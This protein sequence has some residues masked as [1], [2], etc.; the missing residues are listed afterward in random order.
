VAVNIDYH[1]DYDDHYYSVHYGHYMDGHREMEVRATD[2]TV[3]IL[4]AG[5][6]VASHVRSFEKYRHSTKPEHMPASHRVHLEWPPSRIVAW[7][8]SVGPQTAHVV[9]EIM[10]LRP[11]P[12]QGYRSCLGVLRLRDRYPDE[13]IERACARAAKHRTY[14]RRSIEAILKNNLDSIA[15]PEVPQ[16]ALPLHE[17]VRGPGYY[18]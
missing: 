15:E 18:H 10:R 1:V 17:N 5:R 14:S 4:W 7:A 9:E 2:T 3:E 8:S 16:L 13:R 11:H 12:E 6:R